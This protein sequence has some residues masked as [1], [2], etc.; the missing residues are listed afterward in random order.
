MANRKL[1]ELKTIT[2]NDGYKKT[3]A[4]ISYKRTVKNE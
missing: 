1:K 3:E 4:V 2:R